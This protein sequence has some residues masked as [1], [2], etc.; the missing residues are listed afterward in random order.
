MKNK[1]NLIAITVTLLIMN[2]G[3]WGIINIVIRGDALNGKI[4][5]GEYFVAR[6][7]FYTKVS[8]NVYYYSYTHTIFTLASF[9][10]GIVFLGILDLK[11]AKS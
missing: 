4:S 8:A 5:N 10:I 2:F 9:P 3:A 11:Y 1:K 7:G 6:K